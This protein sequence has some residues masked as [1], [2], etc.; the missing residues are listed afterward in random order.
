MMEQLSLSVLLKKKKISHGKLLY[1]T[2][3]AARSSN[4]LEGWEWCGGKGGSTGRGYTYT[5]C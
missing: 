1:S 5:Q 3:S 4:Y 2:R